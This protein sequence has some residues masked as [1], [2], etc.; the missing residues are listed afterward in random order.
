MN[1]KRMLST[2]LLVLIM[3][4]LMTFGYTVYTIRA[5]GTA[6]TNGAALVTKHQALLYAQLVVHLLEFAMAGI[7][8]YKA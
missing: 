8:V 1:L 3:V 4:G 6:N 2:S 5:D 7:V